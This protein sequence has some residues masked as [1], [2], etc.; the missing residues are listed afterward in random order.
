MRAINTAHRSCAGEC[1]GGAGSGVGGLA[2]P[3]GTTPGAPL[4]MLAGSACTTTCL[5][6]CVGVASATAAAL[7]GEFEASTPKYRCRWVRGGGTS[8]AMRFISSSGVRCSSST[9]APR[10]SEPGSLCCY[11]QRYTRAVPSL[12]KAVFVEQYAKHVHLAYGCAARFGLPDFGVAG[13]Q[14]VVC[15]VQR[16]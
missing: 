6:G 1:L 2:W 3:S 13:G 10:F 9:L 4:L 8:V 11:A 7:S 5:A 12:Q 15:A 14:V 16:T